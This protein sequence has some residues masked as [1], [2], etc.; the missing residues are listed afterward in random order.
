MLKIAL[1]WNQACVEI[2]VLR[3][4]KFCFEKPVITQKIVLKTTQI[5]VPLTQNFPTQARVQHKSDFNTRILCVHRNNY[6]GYKIYN[7][8]RES[9]LVF[10]LPG[11]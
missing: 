1:V 4:D 3:K 8:L 5:C 7:L 9:N 2:F 10:S 6:T 11:R